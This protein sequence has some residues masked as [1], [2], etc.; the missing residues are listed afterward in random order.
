VLPG[1][2]ARSLYVGHDEHFAIAGAAI[3]RLSLRLANYPPETVRQGLAV[4]WSYWAESGWI[5]LTLVADGTQGFTTSG[6]IVLESTCGPD[7]AEKTIGEHT[8]FWL[9]GQLN[10]A[11]LPEG[12][13]G[14]GRLPA[15]DVIEQ[16]VEFSTGDL[17]PDAA[18]ANTAPIDIANRFFP[19]GPRP[20]LHTTFFLACEEAFSRKRASVRIRFKLFKE[21]S[22]V[23]P[24]L[25]LSWYYHNGVE[26]VDLSGFS[27]EDATENLTKGGGENGRVV[28]FRCPED[29]AEVDVN[30]TKGF[31]LRIRLDAG[32]Y[33]TPMRLTVADDGSV[34]LAEE[35]YDPPLVEEVRLG[36]E[37]LTLPTLV[38]HCLTCNNEVLTDHSEDAQWP[39]RLFEPF[40]PLDE[41]QPAV[42]FGFDQGFPPGLISLYLHTTPLSVTSSASTLPSPFVW[43]YLSEIGW[44]ELSVRDETAG[45]RASGMLQFV[46]PSDARKT[47]GRGGDLYRVRARLKRGDPI[48][49]LA[50]DG[51]WLNAVWATHR[52]HVAQDIL[53]ISDGNPAQSFSLLR[54]T[55]SVLEGEVVEVREWFGTGQ[56]WVTVVEDA[57]EAEVRLERDRTSGAVNAVWV[58]WRRVAHLF[59]SGPEDRHYTLEPAQNLLR[60][61]DGVHGLIPPA[62]SQVIATYDSGGGVA[63]NV[64]A[65][66]ISELRGAVANLETVTNPVP[67][68]GGADVESSVRI[69]AR[70]PQHLRHRDRAVTAEDFEWVAREASPAV[71]HARCLPLS[72]NAG[73][74]QRGWVTL[75]IAPHSATSQPWP[76]AEL[77]R[78]VLTHIASRCPAAIAAQLRVTGPEYVPISVV[79]EIV[80][81]IADEAAVVEAQVR[82]NLN[83][84]LHPISGGPEGRG[85]RFGEPVYLSQIA[86]IVETETAGVDYAN[87]LRLT[88]GST[89]F[90]DRV[91]VGEH[92]LIASG[93]H[94][95]KV[96]LSSN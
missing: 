37:Y 40:V 45:F 51:L 96:S 64:A 59:N 44:T 22:T 90:G 31:W 83:A 81:R 78:Q 41:L 50:A 32:D 89:M 68:A 77:R 8:S 7:S 26:W 18:F 4:S 46:G 3:I 58:R 9:R 87:Q 95:I 38:D 28:R 94:E 12:A 34:T 39:R 42:H 91:P 21:I 53:G 84:F 10:T 6:E 49:A 79:C 35:S 93:A 30:G 82:A 13:G 62:R 14:I 75:L 56:D 92:M 54:A 65:N 85:W 1:S 69:E 86:Q 88:V 80:P 29:W 27:F 76:S 72:G 47:L 19:F 11:L 70:G 61:G 36:Y 20:A 43:E 71:Y 55:G 24:E 67:A 25:A 23:H 52:E 57:G 73:F 48:A 33:G 66:S 15:I 16:R 17:Q 74:A 63:A 2:V 5:P 60:F